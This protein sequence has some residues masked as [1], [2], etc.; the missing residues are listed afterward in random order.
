MLTGLG[1]AGH[2]I[3]VTS[4]FVIVKG[5]VDDL[6]NILCHQTVIIHVIGF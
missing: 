3:P 5:P 2:D 6:L 4:K 1:G